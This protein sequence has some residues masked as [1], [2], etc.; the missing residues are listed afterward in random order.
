MH[1]PVLIT[2]I[3]CTPQSLIS[4][5]PVLII[6]IIFQRIRGFFKNDMRYI[7]SR[8]TYLLTYLISKNWGSANYGEYLLYATP[9]VFCASR[10]GVMA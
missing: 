7:N 6:Y 8:F 3:I 2:Y 5:P 9:G 4:T 10:C 1:S